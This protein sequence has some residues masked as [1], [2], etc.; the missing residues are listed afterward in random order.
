MPCRAVESLDLQ[1]AAVVPRAIKR[2]KR[3][4]EFTAPDIERRDFLFTV[5]RKLHRLALLKSLV[6]VDSFIRRRERIPRDLAIKAVFEET[7]MTGGSGVPPLFKT[8][9][10]HMTGGSGVSP[11]VENLINSIFSKRRDA[12]SPSQSTFTL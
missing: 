1:S 3:L 8:R 4:L 10:P 9:N 2:I 12:A 6:N 11:L 7:I 5:Q